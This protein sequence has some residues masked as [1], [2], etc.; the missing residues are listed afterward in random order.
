MQKYGIENFSISLLEDNIQDNEINEREKFWISK[1]NTYYQGYNATLGG[2]GQS[3]I[4]R[5]KLKELYDKGYNNKEIAAIMGFERS[6]ISKTLKS[7]GL[8]SNFSPLEKTVLISPKGEEIIFQSRKEAAE[9]LINNNIPR[10]KD[11]STVAGAIGERK[12]DKKPYF[13][14]YCK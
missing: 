7:M 6:N 10:S 11:I 12:N 8:K 14:Y 4:D 13:G 5:I 3:R 2:D 9:Y 1:L